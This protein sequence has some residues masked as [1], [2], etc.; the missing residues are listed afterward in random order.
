[1]SGFL[2]VLSVNLV[3]LLV[4]STGMNY[5]WPMSIIMRALTSDDE[6]EIK[7]CLEQLKV[8]ALCCCPGSL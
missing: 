5:I 7:T 1:M 8:R 6:A 2:L 4:A 3:G